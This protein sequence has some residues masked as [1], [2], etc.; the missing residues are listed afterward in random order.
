MIDWLH[1]ASLSAVA[2]R[3]QLSW[4]E[5]DGIQQRAV[6]RGLARRPA[7]HPVRIGVDETAFQK[8]HA[9]VTVVC[10]LERDVV[11]YVA[12]D[13]QEQSLAP[14]YTPLGPTGCAALEV[15]AMDVWRPYIAAT[16]MAVPDADGKIV[17]DQFHVARLRSI[18]LNQ[19][20]A[21]E[22]RALRAKG[23][24]RWRAPSTGGWRIRNGW[25]PTD[26]GSSAPCARAR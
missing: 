5:V 13:R 12:D 20:R 15:V 21:T 14:F 26:G 19:V 3:L 7:V 22:H 4:D 17:F 2:R 8:H 10:D 25:M 9:Y 1:E 23:G 24:A 6:G 18:A 11:L 16:R